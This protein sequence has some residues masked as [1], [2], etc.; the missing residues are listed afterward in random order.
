MGKDLGKKIKRVSAET[1]KIFGLSSV[2]AGMTATGAMVSG[3]HEAYDLTIIFGT[4]ALA[5]TY[6]AIDSGN[7]VVQ[8]IK[9]YRALDSFNS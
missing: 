6:M 2:V 1:V 7:R 4:L 9:K 5:S 8:A 3:R